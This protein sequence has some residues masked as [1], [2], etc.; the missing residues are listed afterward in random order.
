MLRPMSV[1]EQVAAHLREGLSQGRWSGKMPGRDR[2]AW[3]LG[4]HGSTVERALRQLEKEG[5]LA[6]QGIGRRRVVAEQKEATQRGLRITVVPYDPADNGSDLIGELVHQ[7]KENGHLPAFAPKAL[8]N[9][10]HDPA[11]VAAMIEDQPADGCII[12][13]GSRAV[14]ERISGE[15]PTFALFG[16][17]SGLP[18]AGTG[19]DTVAAIRGAVRF[20]VRN[21]HRKIVKLSREERLKPTPG[22]VET[23]F[24]EELEAHGL[25]H[26]PYNLPPW[27]NTPDGLHSCLDRL[28]RVTPPTAIIVGEWMLYYVVQNYLSRCLGPGK[29]VVDCVCLDEHPSFDWCRPA[30]AHLKWDRR[31][32]VRRAVRWAD[33]L[34]RGEHDMT[35]TA[36]KGRVVNNGS[37]SVIR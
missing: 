28:F 6:S 36:V 13:A 22:G 35:K 12:Q 14:L 11:K 20:L 15:K 17:M 24:L 33:M 32:A 34:A 25:P 27:E 29:Q 21:G 3:E 1:T 19:P 16:S 23:A 9:L 5:L 8:T 18:L 26:G 10:Q 37:I 7:L 2:L 31:T 4:V 30:V